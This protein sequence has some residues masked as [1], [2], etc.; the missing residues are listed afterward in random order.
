M[1]PGG[2][3]GNNKNRNNRNNGNPLW[4]SSN[5]GG[6][7]GGG[8]SSSSSFLPSITGASQYLIPHDDEDGD[9]ERNTDQDTIHENQIMNRN[10]D[11]SWNMMDDDASM[12]S[13]ASANANDE[14]FH[15]MMFLAR[16]GSW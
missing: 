16:G 5:G 10:E 6:G 3:G 7:G 1:S 11:G 12:L 15:R 13:T 4:G 9:S 2:R 14:T 8:S